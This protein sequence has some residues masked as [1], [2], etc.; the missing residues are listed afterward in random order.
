[1]KES[2]IK[3]IIWVFLFAISFLFAELQTSYVWI[4]VILGL[5]SGLN[6]NFRE[7]KT[8]FA[9]VGI[10]ALILVIALS[11][12]VPNRKL[13]TISLSVS[14]IEKHGNNVYIKT[15]EILDKGEITWEELK[16][17]NEEKDEVSQW[18]AVFDRQS[19]IIGLGNA[20]ISQGD[21]AKNVFANQDKE[22]FNIEQRVK[23]LETLTLTQ[24]EKQWLEDLR[25][26]SHE[27]LMSKIVQEG[28][29]KRYD[30]GK[31]KVRY[32]YFDLYKIIHLDKSQ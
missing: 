23:Q 9:A 27:I 28:Y 16:Y 30:F 15:K 22:A 21:Y 10:F 32:L 5:I 13:D 3:A 1:M 18:C 17:L 19:N 11:L 14:N 26:R 6:K 2:R 29:E 31:W 8:S 20:I 4:L 7:Y 24:V 12:T 25:N